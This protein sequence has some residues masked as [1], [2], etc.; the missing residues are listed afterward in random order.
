MKK[1]DKRKFKRIYKDEE[2][3]IYSLI[4]YSVGL[5]RK[6]KLAYVEFLNEKGEVSCTKIYFSTNLE[7]KAEK[8]LQY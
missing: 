7:R 2:K 3:I 8:I 6:L 5:Q 4:V 1:I